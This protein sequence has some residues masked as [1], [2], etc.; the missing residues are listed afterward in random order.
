MPQQI[1]YAALADQARR[2]ATQPPPI[3]YAALAAQVR[4]TPQPSR[5]G[6][7]QGAAETLTDLAKGAG[8]ALV[9]EG[10]RGG[11][12]LRKIPG[13]SALDSLMA[14]IEV[15]VEP[16]NPTQQVGGVLEQIGE[17]VAPSKAI[18]KLGEKAATTIAPRL[19]ATI[20]ERLATALPKVAV[21]GAGGAALAAAQGGS[22]VVGGLV[23][24]A[25]PAVAGA[26][27]ALPA[28]LRGQ[29]SKQ[30]E[31]ALGAT[32]ERYKAMAQRL[33]PEILKRGLR[34]SREALQQRA[35][36]TVS[37][38]GD[39]IDQ[40]L[41]QYGGREIV[42]APVVEA[43][44]KA[45]DA[46]RV[47]TDKPLPAMEGAPAF[48][49]G[50]STAKP[51]EVWFHALSDARKQ[52]YKGNIGELR[53]TFMERVEQAKAL[54]QEAAHSEAEYGTEAFLKAIRDQGGLRPFTKD[55]HGNK[56]R[57][58][59]AS[60]VESF[61]SKST[62]GQKGGATIFR[63]KGQ[64][65]DDMAERLSNDPKWSHLISN[66][67]DLIDVLDDIARTGPT[68]ADGG[69]IEHYLRATGVVPG[70][71]W[72][73]SSGPRVVEIESRS[74]RQLDKLQ[75]TIKAL[76]PEARVD[77]LVAVRRAW[78]HVVSQA[79]GFQHRAAG[80]IGVPLQDTSEA[81]AKRE[82]AGAI[83]KL[84]DEGVPELTPINKEFHFWKSLD[85][86]LRQ[87]IQRKGPQSEG[88]IATTREAA[89]Q[90]AGAAIKGGTVG[91]A[92]ALGK[93]SKMANAVFTSPRWRLA[94]AQAKDRLAQAIMDNDASEIAASLSRITA[95]QGSKLVPAESR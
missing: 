76:G 79:G 31:Q 14:P 5:L 23:G 66:E 43:L 88:L 7:Y 20:G 51:D 21:E 65:I 91:T 45:K 35:A 19:S 72:W 52:G 74:L 69:G 13:V 84:L 83:R 38:V 90:V 3:D 49:T 4:Q 80:A 33:T 40:A 37:E 8:K 44:E 22:P 67:N 68:K 87:T 85:D 60:I 59:F 27:R 58:D 34:G 11:A 47:V 54:Q 86:V 28:N 70:A 95:V 92:F 94:S 29:A 18:L 15:P 75:E 39:R 78:D 93:V 62:W 30:V 61:G 41:Q 25:V 53:A 73:E 71:K 56:M 55:I 50:K 9:R 81:W 26:V 10:I 46:F 48:F 64:T 24:A 89:G 36:E 17:T 63:T 42:T 1:D 16:T 32:K 77:H 57:G 6:W 82:G 12:L 2:E